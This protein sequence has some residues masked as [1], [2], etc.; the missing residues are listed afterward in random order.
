[1]T[2][3][4]EILRLHMSERWMCKGYGHEEKSLLSLSRFYI[5]ASRKG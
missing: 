5:E 1:M 2:N 3:Y 4:R